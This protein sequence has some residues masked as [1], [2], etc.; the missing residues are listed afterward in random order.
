MK[1]NYALITGKR[2][3]P[4]CL[5]RKYLFALGSASILMLLSACQSTKTIDDG[6]GMTFEENS[7]ADR[8]IVR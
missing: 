1:H 8:V 6:Y 4:S 2:L 5:F 7:S 3:K